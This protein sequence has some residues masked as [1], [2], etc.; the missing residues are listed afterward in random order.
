MEKLP[1][2]IVIHIFSFL[3]ASDIVS[4]Q[5]VAARY[6]HIGR[7]NNL[8]KRICYENSTSEALRRR[9][10]LLASQDSTLLTLRQALEASVPLFPLEEAA[11]NAVVVA[12]K[13]S[14]AETA[15]ARALANWDSTYPSEYTNFY[16][17]F[18]QRHAPITLR[19]LE[20]VAS[21]ESG[22]ASQLESTGIG[23]LED[24][25]S[26]KQHLIS[27]LEDGS[28]CI[29]DLGASQTQRPKLI[30]RSSPGFLFG[31]GSEGT[32]H[33]AS[34][35][36]ETEATDNVAVDNSQQK[37]YV[38]TVNQ[39]N[40]IDI[41]TMQI[42]RR[43]LFPF[44]ITA[45]S[46]A[47]SPLPITVGTNMTL[48]LFD[49]R[50]SQTQTIVDNSARCELIGGIPNPTTTPISYSSEVVSLSQP[51]P[52]SILHGPDPA[53]LHSIWVAGRFTSL[54]HYD[55]RFW[56]RI[57]STL[58]SGAR[59]SS[60][61]CIPHP[62]IPRSLDL[63]RNPDAT[64]TDLQAA[65]SAPG[66]TLLACGEYKGKGSLEL[67]GI[68]TPPTARVGR[69]DEFYRNRQ[70]AAKSRLLSVAPH[71]TRI[72]FS[73]GDGNVK[74]TERDGSSVVRNFNINADA[75]VATQQ[76]LRRAPAP[77][78]GGLFADDNAGPSDIVRKIIPRSSALSGMDHSS[79][80]IPAL[81][82]NDLI[83]W[84]GEGRLGILGFGRQTSLGEDADE[85]LRDAAMTAEEK[86]KE[87]QER[88][89]GQ[90]M[91]EALERQANETRFVRGLGLGYG[92]D[93]GFRF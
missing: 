85:D 76:P 65:R 5:A 33:F 46:A 64:L 78:G 44:P 24:S 83:L 54:L 23:I 57:E 3:E 4:V 67:Y 48:H 10:K 21:G 42:T 84:T 13:T 47:Q 55:R 75:L 16:G 28:V 32:P 19:Y 74:W 20:G 41:N 30:S 26:V 45:L 25:S 86:A 11:F 9:Q 62:Y 58:F 27:S 15:K 59:L 82:R 50:V 69:G 66:T 90:R 38:A 81:P 80:S 1:H 87:A 8:W 37:A 12:P 39:L 88:M 14:D 93:D 36:N 7:D 17:E 92:F 22:S 43:Q 79:T 35:S 63:T 40:E 34:L 70:T 53:N 91:R 89:Y 71:G 29:Y 68:G 60:L 31:S 49:P 56:P 72:V 61:S 51:G 2:E 18:V 52:L 73:D 6:Y 77:V